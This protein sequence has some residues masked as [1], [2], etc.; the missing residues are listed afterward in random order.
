MVV[1]NQSVLSR[2]HEPG[3]VDDE[4]PAG[5]VSQVDVL[6]AADPAGVVREP[7]PEGR[8]EGLTCIHQL[9]LP[10]QG[11][12]S[13][14]GGSNI[15]G[16][17]V[18]GA[19]FEFLDQLMVERLVELKQESM[20]VT[21]GS[22]EGPRARALPRACVAQRVMPDDRVGD[23]LV[24]EGLALFDRWFM[25]RKFLLQAEAQIPEGFDGRPLRGEHGH[26]V[27]EAQLVHAL[28]FLLQ[29]KIPR[30]EAHSHH[31]Q[32]QYTSP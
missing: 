16:K 21:H 12:D 2:A 4:R 18:L 25:G 20:V 28:G 27:A 1:L 23:H 19:R 14:L 9:A 17:V 8:L 24:E 10:E 13:H 3:P 15:F 11:I 26:L 31:K 30:R 5:Y 6:T 7:T 22:S 29:V 32:Y